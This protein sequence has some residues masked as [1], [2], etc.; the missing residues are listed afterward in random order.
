MFKVLKK[1][2]EGIDILKSSVN[3]STRQLMIME[4]ELDLCNT[5]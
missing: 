1:Q 2:K 5:N 4:R 3:D